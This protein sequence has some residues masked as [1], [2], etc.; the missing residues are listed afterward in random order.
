M[1][2]KSCPVFLVFIHRGAFQGKESF[3]SSINMLWWSN[4]YYP[5]LIL[6]PFWES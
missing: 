5:E 3:H 4:F 6:L 2:I 1:G